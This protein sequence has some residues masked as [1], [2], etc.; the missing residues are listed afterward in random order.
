MTRR[1][2]VIL[3][4]DGTIIV[5]RHYLSDPEGVELLP[6]VASGLRRLST[7]GLGL[8]VIT[9][10]SGIGRRLFNTTQLALIHQR[11]CALLEREGIQLD[12]I[13]VCPH[14]PEDDCVCRK[15]KTGLLDQAAK[16]LDFDPED[17][18]V[19]GDKACDI[20]L[21]QRVG[22][23]TFLVRTGYGT[24]VAADPTVSPDYVVDG[25]WEA[26]QVIERLLVGNTRR[27]RMRPDWNHLERA[28]A[29]LLESAEI[30]RQVA[31]ECLH[32]ILAAADLIAETFRSG[33]KVLLC[34][35]G[36]SAADCQHMAAELVSRLT[37]DFER[38]GL[39]AI[40]LTTDTSFLTAYAND[41]GFEGIFERQVQALGKPADVLIGISTSG[42]SPNVIRAAEA[43]QAASMRTVALTGSGG[44]L[45]RIAHVTVSVPSTN[46][47]YIQEAHLAIEHILCE[48][49]EQS[50]FR[51]QD[52][53]VVT[54]RWV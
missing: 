42:N 53:S 26:A 14:T 6:R 11:L 13:Y 16:D 2:F 47:Q 3:D 4:R 22:A 17:A 9:N 10:Q 15:P 21:G 19:I 18:F 39:P 34:G 12:G 45:A 25:T 1:R 43:A 20:E 35:N 54:A 24:Q 28:R 51:E 27:E 46:T 5:E 29:H 49:V 7:M 40:A 8:V 50:L 36:G 23:A 37:K 33:G 38:P 52:A 32:S 44:H 48:L 31:E 41:C 30:K